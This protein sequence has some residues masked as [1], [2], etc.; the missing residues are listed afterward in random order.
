MYYDEKIAL[1]EKEVRKKEKEERLSSV[2]QKNKVTYSIDIFQAEINAGTVFVDQKK[3]KIEPKKFMR[4]RITIPYMTDLFGI[5]D[6]TDRTVWLGCSKYDL[7]F[8]MAMK[9]GAIERIPVSELKEQL[10]EQM[11]ANKLYCKMVKAE[12][13]KYLDYLCYETPTAAGLIYNVT[14][15]L[16][17]KNQYFIGTFSCKNEEQES[18]GILLEALVH[19]IN[20]YKTQ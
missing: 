16:T 15:R 7:T 3:L 9:D 13:L 17:E 12:A 14:F 20:N 2:A 4:D 11:G 5:E 6:I 18:M 1:L 8:T 19:E 10:K